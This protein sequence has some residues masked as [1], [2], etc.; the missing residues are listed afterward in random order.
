MEALLSN[1]DFS[2]YSII[3]VLFGFIVGYFVCGIF[4]A[5]LSVSDYFSDLMKERKRL[6]KFKEV[7][8]DEET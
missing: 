4:F 2:D 6:K 8:L 5:L 7:K 3:L 1:M